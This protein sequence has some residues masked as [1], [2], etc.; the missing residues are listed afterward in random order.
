MNVN[1]GRPVFLNL[2]RIRQPVTAVVSIL[3]RISGF[4]MVLLLPA[5]I[6]LLQLSLSSPEGFYR[7]V[8]L[9]DHQFTR[10]S[11][12]L[13]CWSFA[14]HFLSGIRFILQ[15][16]CC[17]LAHIIRTAYVVIT[18]PE[19]GLYR[20]FFYRLCCSLGWGDHHL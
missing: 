15:E 2:L 7:V 13:I 18:A 10:V 14:H 5:L 12:I 19:R 17:E 8:S 6:Y 3:H 11:G 4:F 16:Y 1:Q 9:L 20:H